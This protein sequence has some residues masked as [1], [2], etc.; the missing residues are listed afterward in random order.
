VAD[1]QYTVVRLDNGELW[2]YARDLTLLRDEV[3]IADGVWRQKNAV[4]IA[5]QNRNV[6]VPAKD[7]VAITAAGYDSVAILFRD[8]V[9]FSSRTAMIQTYVLPADLDVVSAVKGLVCVFILTRDGRLFVRE[10][11]TH[12][13]FAEIAI[14]VLKIVPVHTQGRRYHH[15][16]IALTAAGCMFRCI[17]SL[18]RAHD[19]RSDPAKA[20]Q[21][22]VTPHPNGLELVNSKSGVHDVFVGMHT[23]STQGYVGVW[24]H[25]TGT[26]Y[27]STE[28]GSDGPPRWG[29]GSYT[30]AKTENSM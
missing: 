29:Y 28:C 5:Y 19:S 27:P 6:V 30:R 16:C 17:D 14:D 9:T 4:R 21:K 1:V 2:N 12:T 7:A 23:C 25:R 3:P 24:A 13:V 11:G 15:G 18:T 20:C 8:R 10:P 26:M 22:V